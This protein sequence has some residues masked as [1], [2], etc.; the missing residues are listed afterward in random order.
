VRKSLKSVNIWQS[1]KQERDCLVHFVRLA[2]ALLKDSLVACFADI[3]VSQ[4]NVAH[5]QGA[6]GVFNVCKS[7][8]T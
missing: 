1:Y 3:N 6:V 7:V 2:N 8:K 5:M 4:G